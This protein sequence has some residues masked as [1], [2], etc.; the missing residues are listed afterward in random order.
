MQLSFIPHW[1]NAEGGDDV[2]TSRCFVGMERF[3]AWCDSLP[4]DNTTVGLDEH[5]GLII[6]FEKRTCQVNGVSSVSLVREC[7][8]RMYPAGATFPL[9]ELGSF[10]PVENIRAGIPDAVW[11]LASAAQARADFNPDAE[12][13]ALLEKRRKARSSHNWAESDRL[14]E[15]IAAR[16]WNVQDNKDDQQLLKK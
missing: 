7:D 3:A 9:G 16:G 12:V 5:T 14:R 6:D 10:R 11:E 13:L 8:P 1:N 15:D 2:D 4:P